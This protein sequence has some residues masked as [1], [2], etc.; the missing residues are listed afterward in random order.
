MKVENK[1]GYW[2]TMPI[3]RERTGGGDSARSN[4]AGTSGSPL[5][6]GRVLGGVVLDVPGIFRL[7]I[8]GCAGSGWGRR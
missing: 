7:N 8:V 5:V 3:N 1:N 4:G 6:D 2:R